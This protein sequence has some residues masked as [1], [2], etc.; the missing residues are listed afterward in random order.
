MLL[1]P[2]WVGFSDTSPSILGA[3]L[4]G[5]T[6]AGLDMG[7]TV[8]SVSTPSGFSVGRGFGGFYFF[9]LR[10]RLVKFIRGNSMNIQK[11][12]GQF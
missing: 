2:F 11:K 5:A 7:L 12:R 6:F 10:S 9:R 1:A 4:A 3:G 8:F